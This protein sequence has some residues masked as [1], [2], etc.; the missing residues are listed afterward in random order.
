[1]YQYSDE[2]RREIR[3]IRRNYDRMAEVNNRMALI[4]YRYNYNK[5]H[6]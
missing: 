1:M 4:E 3:A 6:I 5:R 2:E